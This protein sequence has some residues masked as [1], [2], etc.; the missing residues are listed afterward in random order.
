[1]P[2][3]ISDLKAPR[4]PTG[5]QPAPSPAEI[6]ELLRGVDL[7]GMLSDEDLER[8]HAK[9]QVRR[10]KQGDYLFREGDPPDAVY[11]ILSGVIEVVRSTPDSPEPTTVAYISPGEAMGD[12]AVFT[13]TQR[14]SAARVP[15]FA[16]VFTLD[17]PAFERLARSVPGYGLET[18]AIFARRLE[19]FITRMRGQKRRKE[20]S[21]NLQFFD[22]P[23][24][25]QT[26]V[27]S[28]QTGV[29][30]ITDENRQTYA[31]VLLLDGAVERARCGLME[32]EEAFF[33]LFHAEDSGQFF[34]RTVNDPRPETISDVEISGSA[35][36][37]LMEAIRRVDEFP[38][39][40]DRIPDRKK[41]YQAL[42]KKLKWKEDATKVFAQEVLE[43]LRDPRPIGELIAEVSCSTFTLYWVLAELYESGQIG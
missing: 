5:E 15:E 39:V 34:F 35:M 11:V 7:F 31:E 2:P 21:G 14:R 28:N 4:P 25:V 1:M 19:A 33:Q 36:Y 40:R 43:K 10:L 18:A 22:L 16:D 32:G 37:L 26:L 38:A 3:S 20:L 42:V 8:V 17:R 13:G 23:T 12:M 6:I 30:T 9:G 29:L 24:V 27:G 41:P